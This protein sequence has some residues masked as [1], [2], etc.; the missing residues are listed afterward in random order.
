MEHRID[1]ALNNHRPDLFKDLKP[2]ARDG[3]AIDIARVPQRRGWIGIANEADDIC[4]EFQQPSDEVGADHAG[5]AGY[6][7]APGFPALAD[8]RSFHAAALMT[9]PSM[10]GKH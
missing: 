6:E 4:A 8:L 2:T 5:G 1:F 10:E 9:R 3:N 7:H